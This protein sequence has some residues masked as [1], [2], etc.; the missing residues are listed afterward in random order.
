[1]MDSKQTIE[2]LKNLITTP[3]FCKNARGEYLLVNASFERLLGSAA[4]VE[5][6]KARDIL[7]E[8][9]AAEDERRDR[10]ALGR[11]GIV[12]YDIEL[13]SGERKRTFTCRKML[14]PGDGSTEDVIACVMNE[15]TA[16]VNTEEM[17]RKFSM[18]STRARPPS[19]SPIP[20][21]SSGTSTRP[22][23]GSPGIPRK[24]R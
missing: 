3:F 7:D 17:L 16:R 24:R 20:T 18:A 14:L 8:D 2:I 12:N 22:S 10:E 11:R 13:G 9:F 21:A 5:G 1:M 19:S 4:P 15:T 23:P 6:K